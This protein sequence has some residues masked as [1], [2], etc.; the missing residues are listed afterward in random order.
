MELFF[1]TVSL[2]LGGLAVGWVVGSD[3]WPTIEKRLEE[4]FDRF[5]NM[6]VHKFLVIAGA[7]LS[8]AS[9]LVL[10]QDHQLIFPL[11]GWWIGVAALSVGT[12]A[13]FSTVRRNNVGD[14]E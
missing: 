5:T 7:L 2:I 8:V 6:P 9:G 1:S 11:I 12:A 13:W 14:R 10:F 3:K 4:L